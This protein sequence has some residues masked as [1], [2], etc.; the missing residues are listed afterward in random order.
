[1]TQ[2]VLFPHNISNANE[3]G[4]KVKK[5]GKTN[6]YAATFIITL[7]LAIV[8]FVIDAIVSYGVATSNLPFW[9]KYWV[10]S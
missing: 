4:K 10:L 8:A 6:W 9:V 1:M 2:R 7:I 3:G 5:Q